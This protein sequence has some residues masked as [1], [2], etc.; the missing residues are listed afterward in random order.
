M[1]TALLV[2]LLTAAAC[3]A[4]PLPGVWVEVESGQGSGGT[5]PNPGSSGGG[6]VAWW[7]HVGHWRSVALTVPQTIDPAV[8]YLR[9]MAMRAKASA[10]NRRL[11]FELSVLDV[12]A[13]QL[14]LA[15]ARSLIE[16][17]RG[18][19]SSSAGLFANIA[20][21]E[22]KRMFYAEAGRHIYGACPSPDGRHLLFTRSEEDL[23][24]V[25]QAK[26][27]MALIRAA[28]TPMLGDQDA[29]LHERY[30]NAKA[31]RRLDLGAGWEPHWTRSEIPNLK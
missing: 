12:D 13:D 29:A 28:D 8:V 16:R 24:R 26:T 5:R 27:T 22:E 15:T 21:G 11:Q 9:Y 19:G 3:T 4:D 10:I 30:P 18:L 6:E 7:G 17:L 31:S 14:D 1:R 25:D 2:C 20:D 23:G